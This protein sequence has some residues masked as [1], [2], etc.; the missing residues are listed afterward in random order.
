[1]NDVEKRK[2]EPLMVKIGNMVRNAELLTIY[3][4]QIELC[5]GLIQLVQITMLAVQM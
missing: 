2:N 3:I 1:M 4:I 5:L